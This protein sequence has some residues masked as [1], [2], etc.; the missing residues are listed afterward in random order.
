MHMAEIAAKRVVQKVGIVKLLMKNVQ[1]DFL[2]FSICVKSLNISK[3]TIN[4]SQPEYRISFFRYTYTTLPLK[5]DTFSQDSIESNLYSLYYAIDIDNYEVTNVLQSML[6]LPDCYLAQK[7]CVLDLE[8]VW[9][10]VELNMTLK[11]F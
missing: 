2:P 8:V 9:Y 7:P 3:I 1:F 11:R 10:A 5:G 4:L 6:L